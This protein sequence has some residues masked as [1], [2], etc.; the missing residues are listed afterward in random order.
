MA[1]PDDDLQRA[2]E[3]YKKDLSARLD[4][5]YPADVATPRTDIR[6]LASASPAFAAT[7]SRRRGNPAQIEITT[8]LLE[9]VFDAAAVIAAALPAESGGRP[10][11]QQLSLDD[12]YDQLKQLAQAVINGDPAPETFRPEGRRLD[13]S[14]VLAGSTLDF[15][16]AHELQHVLLGHTDR[17]LAEAALGQTAGKIRIYSWAEEM[18]ADT[19]GL[20]GILDVRHGARPAQAAYFGPALFFELEACSDTQ[21]D[22]FREGADAVEAD[23]ARYSSHPPPQARRSA[24]IL[25]TH[26]DGMRARLPDVDMIVE[27]VSA[28]RGAA[29]P[30]PTDEQI[31][32]LRA[33]TDATPGAELDRLMNVGQAENGLT[34]LDIRPIL[35]KIKADAEWARGAVARAALGMLSTPLASREA[36]RIHLGVL[37]L[38]YSGV[39]LATPEPTEEDRMF[40][41]L[42]RRCVPD[43]DLIMDQQ[44]RLMYAQIA[45]G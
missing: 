15:V 27:L 26:P 45:D 31:E 8:G 4:S 28:A 6:M 7:T 17:T 30:E 37:A 39:Y 21:R 1:P 20:A 9:A 44:A 14:Y 18:A 29:M 11:A 16:I 22:A 35:D 12:A 3:F 19:A 41:G 40:S 24:L 10:L 32:R 34:T 23:A 36:Y 5:L 38:L 42:V 33:Y 43:I 13:L 25:A 2:L